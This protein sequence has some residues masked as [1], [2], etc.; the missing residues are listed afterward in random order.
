MKAP[1]T[2]KAKARID[3]AVGVLIATHE[4]SAAEAHRRLESAAILAGVA[5]ISVA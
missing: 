3:N 5:P 4:V 1:A 2:L